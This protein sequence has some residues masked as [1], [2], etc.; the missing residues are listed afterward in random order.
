MEEGGGGGR[1][2]HVVVLH[3]ST[4]AVL[5]RRQ[6]D[7]YSPHEDESMS[8]FLNLVRKGRIIIM[9]V[10]VSFILLFTLCQTLSNN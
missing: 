7:T 4:G 2:I 5:A 3:Q 1:G 8:L 10:K 9:A 6:F